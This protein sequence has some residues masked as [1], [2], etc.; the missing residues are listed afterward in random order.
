MPIHA[1]P[2]RLP[3]PYLVLL[4][5]VL[6]ASTASIFIRFAQADAVP[7]LVIA[8]GRLTLA[9]LI[10]TPPTLR[11]HH[12]ELRRLSPKAIGLALGAGIF[13]AIH[14]ASWITS[15][16]Y[17][18]VLVSVVLVTTSPL[19]VALLAPLL[20]R[21]PIQ[22]RTL[23]GIGVAF[24]GGLLISVAGSGDTAA[25]GSMPVLGSL[26]SLL[27]ALAAAFYLIIGRRL[28]ASL[29]L[30]P[31][32]WLV[33]GAAALTLLVSV[34]LSGLPLTGYPP[35]TYLWMLLLA[36]VPQL[37]GHSSFNYALAHL[38]ASHVGLVILGEPAG[39]A[40]LAFFFLG[41]SP[42]LIQVIGA[43]LILLGILS[44]RDRTSEPAEAVAEAPTP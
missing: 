7:S 13:L 42:T 41:E 20:L 17:V 24:L 18:S 25:T 27:G 35:Q 26:L 3:S 4:I 12:A 36:L 34:A 6:A 38:P 29:S 39:S 19:W 9:A 15:L 10:L 16:E 30:L 1:R 21:E 32:I 43:G 5:G 14:F 8:A 33:Y 11:R 23:A 44:A 2:S 37:I 40:I 28:R 22:R 31:Y